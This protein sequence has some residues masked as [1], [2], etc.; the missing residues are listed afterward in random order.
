ML[1]PPDQQWDSWF[2]TELVRSVYHFYAFVSHSEGELDE[3]KEQLWR[4]CLTALGGST[5]HVKGNGK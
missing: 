1:K 2:V 4:F 3:V 5:Q